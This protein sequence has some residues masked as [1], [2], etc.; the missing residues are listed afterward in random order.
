MQEL[1]VEDIQQV[2]GGDLDGMLWGVGEGF[3]TGM[4]V[5]T[6][7]GGRG[8]L[9]APVAQLVGLFVGPVVGGIFGAFAGLLSNRETVQAYAAHYRETYGLGNSS[10][11]D[12]DG[13][14]G[15]FL[16]GGSSHG[17]RAY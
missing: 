7:I 12:A 14:F 9:F 1:T 13:L 11:G 3:T 10:G 15:N 8:G 16:G 2:A 4:A 6:A 5:G 17:P